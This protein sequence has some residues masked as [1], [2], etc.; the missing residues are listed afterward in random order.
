MAPGLNRC[1]TTDSVCVC[2]YVEVTES[3][4]SAAA[5]RLLE[6]LCREQQQHYHH[7]QVASGI[8]V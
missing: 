8:T 1:S 7:L 6:T 5:C 4:D 3:R 2:V